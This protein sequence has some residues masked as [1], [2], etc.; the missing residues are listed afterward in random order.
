MSAHL[1]HAEGCR[2]PVAPKLLA[3]SRHWRMVPQWLQRALHAVYVPGQESRKDPTWEYV[4]VQL[5]CRIAIAEAEHK[6]DAVQRLRGE[7][8]RWL[9]GRLD[10]SDPSAA[11]TDEQLIHG[12]FA[13]MEQA[14]AGIPANALPF[15]RR[16]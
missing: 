1:C 11:L 7:L 14:T 3:C 10:P 13:T 4:A 6:P 12:I 9:R 5:R 15:R 8:G 2:V 16:R